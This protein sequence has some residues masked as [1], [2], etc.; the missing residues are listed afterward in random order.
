MSEPRNSSKSGSTVSNSG[1]VMDVQ[2]ATEKY[3]LPAEQHVPKGYK[4]TEVGVIPEDWNLMKLEDISIISRLAGAEY[5]SLWKEALDGEIIALRGFNIGKGRIVERDFVRISNELSLKLKRSRLCKGDVVYPCVG[6]IGNAVV[7]NENCKYHIQQNI[8][9]ITPNLVAISSYFLASYLMS[10]LGE[11]EIARFNASSSQPS[12]LVKSLR[13]YHI[14]TPPTKAEQEAIAE[15]LSDA[16]T[17]IEALEQL[18]AKKRQLKQ[19]A[20]QEL[21]TGKRRLPGFSGEWTVK[22]FGDLVFPRKERIDPRKDGIQEFCVELEHIGSAIGTLLGSTVAGE[23]AS[24]KTVFHAGDVLFGK[25][26]SY[27]RKYW[28]A[29]KFGVCSTEIWA[30]TPIENQLLNCFLFQVIQTNDFIEVASSSYGTHMPRSD[31]S[32][33]KQ[34]EVP[35][36]STIEEQTAIAQILTDMDADITNLETKLTKARAVK[37]GMMQQLLTGKIRLI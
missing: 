8:A 32:V 31:W 11:K 6:S 9:R 5:T 28:F 2:E 19:G 18:V 34:Y 3:L 25:L 16:D 12:V 29:D 14:A 17:L 15:A 30:L 35:F 22:K 1:M 33:V 27:L 37:Q 24:M 21:L 7:I 23:N 4:Q 13:Q 26:R 36:P 10:F 20:M